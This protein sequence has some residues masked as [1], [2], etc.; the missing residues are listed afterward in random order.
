M[1]CSVGHR[2]CSDPALL[3][4]RRRLAAVVPIRPLAWEL[5]YAA[6]VAVKRKKEKRKRKRNRN[7]WSIFS[8]VVLRLAVGLW[9]EGV[10]PPVAILGTAPC[11]A[12]RL[13]GMKGTLGDTQPSDSFPQGPQLTGTPLSHPSEKFHCCQRCQPLQ[14]DQQLGGTDG[15]G[16]LSPGSS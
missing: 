13:P 11:L 1:S 10:A 9:N 8:R 15:S 5:P 14:E 2:C 7:H 12:S 3:W 6:D 16:G 4:L